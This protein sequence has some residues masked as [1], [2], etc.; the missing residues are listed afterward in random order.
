MELQETREAAGDLLAELDRL[1]ERLDAAARALA[2]LRQEREQLF[3]AAGVRSAQ[4]LLR[5]IEEWNRAEGEN[6]SLQQERREAAGRLRALIDKVDMLPH[7][8]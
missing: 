6:R 2:G 8:A 4:A 1:A 3:A 7:D 5:R